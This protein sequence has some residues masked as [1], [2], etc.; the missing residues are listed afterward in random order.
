M[1]FVDVIVIGAGHNGL[2]C[3]C[4]LA[5]AGLKVR[6][7]ER[8]DV[9]GGAAVT[10]EFFPGF[11]N[12]SASYTVSLLNPVVIRDLHLA[13]RGLKI[14]GRPFS[15]FLP[16]EDGRYLKFGG[17][18]ASAHAEILKFSSADA[19]RFGDY[20]Q[21]LERIA[22]QVKDWVLRAPPELGGPLVARG[23][24]DLAGAA[25]LLW[26]FGR[27]PRQVQRDWVELFT[28]SAGDWL[29]ESFESD[30]L[31]A[32]LGW[33]SIVGNYASPYAPGSAYVLLH[34][35]LGQVD[36]KAGAWGH[37]IG[38]MGR[39]TA[40]MAEE[41]RSR[42]VQIDLQAGVSRILAERGAVR[43]VVLQDGR[44]LHAR[45]VVAGVDP[46]RLYLKL[47]EPQALPADFLRS[48]RSFR[49]GSGS[50]RINVALSELPDFRCLPGTQAQ[51]HHASGI[52]LAPSLRAMDL[53][54]RDALHGG[55][56]KAPIVE[57]LIPSVVDDTL[58][59]PGA[60]VASLF[61]QHFD[62]D[63][64]AG[65]DALK[66]AAVE[67]VFAQV[68]AF[69]PNFRRAL[70]GYRA[71][72]PLDLERD[73]GLTGGDIFHGQLSPDQLF[74]LRPLFGYAR[75]RGPLDGLY[76][77]GSGAHPGGGV[78]GAPGH[79]AAREIVRD[80]GRRRAARAS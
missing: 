62:P 1:D 20:S 65:W 32:A 53:A 49:C 42:G 50:M 8:R 33:D 25:R 43:G 61:C 35:A 34:H 71:W 28:K 29:D 41:A 70:L 19:E 78:S 13:Q 63:P 64:P 37:A 24:R 57:M 4:Y 36:G 60:H 6:V 51:P 54:W 56:S 48:I 58:A 21:R 76:H 44:E 9:V 3:S 10:E 40:L 73:F 74:S 2:T 30:C 31:K 66:P 22:S 7:L 77:C 47:L 5:S 72:T 17:A 38:G 67:A 14:V 23:W 46:K 27:L 16:T 52:L 39:I 75:Y 45:A 11:R 12:S 80:L 55:H 69:C 26:G 15:N 59:P 79:N 68:E 18:S